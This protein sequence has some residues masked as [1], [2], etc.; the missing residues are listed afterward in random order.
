MNPPVAELQSVSRSFPLGDTSVSVLKQVDLSIHPGERIV[1]FGSSG[2]GK[3][4]LLHLLALLDLPS[5]G[6]IR[7]ANQSTSTLSE[8]ERAHLRAIHIGLVFQR[9][10]LLPFHTVRE[11]IQLRSRYVNAPASLHNRADH[12]LEDMGLKDLEDQPVRFLSGGEQQR[13]CIARALLFPPSLLLADE[14]TGNLDEAN[15]ARVRHLFEG[16]SSDTPIVLATHDPG[17]LPFA[18]RVLRFENGALIEGET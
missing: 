12:L 2:C 3:T 6:E 9:F 14:P 16:M 8:K 5:S 13:V 18:T 11:N 10:H 17:W 7:F 4:T 1:L 15:S